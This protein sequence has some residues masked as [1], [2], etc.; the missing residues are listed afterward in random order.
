MACYVP[1]LDHTET[2]LAFPW[3]I[4]K[5]RVGCQGKCAYTVFGSAL[6]EPTLA[7]GWCAL[8]WAAKDQ[9]HASLAFSKY[10]SW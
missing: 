7:L 10:L 5:K 8:P 4:V 3:E 1:P 6:L 2:P 9:P